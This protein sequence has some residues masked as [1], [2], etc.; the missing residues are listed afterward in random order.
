[1]RFDT[2]FNQYYY[3]RKLDERVGIK[4]I[5]GIIRKTKTCDFWLVSCFFAF[6]VIGVFEY[7]FCLFSNNIPKLLL[8][9]PFVIDI[10]LLIAL[11]IRYSR[12]K[13]EYKFYNTKA[14]NYSHKR[15]NLI[16]GLLRE[17]GIDL[18]D[19][20]TLNL[21]I[22]EAELNKVKYDSLDQ[23]K[24]PIKILRALLVPSA[25]IFVIFLKSFVE[26]TAELIAER[27]SLV[28]DYEMINKLGEP[29]VVLAILIF[30]S[31]VFSLLI[32]PELEKL[33]KRKYY[34]HEEF[35]EDVRQ[36]IIFQ[37]GQVEILVDNN[38]IKE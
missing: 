10:G 38:D 3:K 11:A 36:I 13:E 21:L 12:A 29:L 35:I 8:I 37:K 25:T 33:I 2:L 16:K 14:K 34:Y 1:M 30:I 23:F 27:T 20:E 18:N 4:E 31:L 6:A 7:I 15:I 9:I 32:F 19:R 17:Y 5:D 26:K 24:K 28:V 22:E